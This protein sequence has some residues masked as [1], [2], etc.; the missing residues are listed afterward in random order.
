MFF[1]KE[2]MF[3]ICKMFSTDQPDGTS[4]VISL[5]RDCHIIFS[6]IDTPG[7]EHQR[8]VVS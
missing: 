6:E 2:K 4:V 1:F 8:S 3:E 7:S 5:L